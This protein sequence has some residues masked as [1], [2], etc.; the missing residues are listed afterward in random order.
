MAWITQPGIWHTDIDDK[1][2]KGRKAKAIT[3][4]PTPGSIVARADASQGS[5]AKSSAVAIISATYTAHRMWQGAGPATEEEFDFSATVTYEWL[6][7]VQATKPGE[8]TA[9][10]KASVALL[11]D[12]KAIDTQTIVTETLIAPPVNKKPQAQPNQGINVAIPKLK[13]TSNVVF[14]VNLSVTATAERSGEGAR[15]EAMASLSCSTP[16]TSPP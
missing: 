13:H 12:G 10:A 1:S 11:V 6:T 14:S 2:E 7:D 3:D 15:A 8:A 16:T 5:T 9:S 4:D